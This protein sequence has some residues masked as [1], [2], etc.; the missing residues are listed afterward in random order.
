MKVEAVGDAALRVTVAETPGAEASARVRALDA[1][2]RAAA[3]PGVRAIVPAYTTLLVHFD[4]L[5]AGLVLLSDAIAAVAPQTVAPPQRRWHIAATYD[6]EDLDAVA[7]QLGLSP[8]A[9]VA[10]HSAAQY[11]VACL[12]FAPGFAYLT[13]LPTAL[14]VPRRASP[15]PQIP[16]G[17]LIV[18]GQQTAVMPLPLPSGWHILGRTHLALFDAARAEPSLLLPGDWVRFVPTA[19]A[20]LA[21]AAVR[22]E[23][24]P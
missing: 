8:A 19:A 18:G 11:A 15:R 3:L 4:P 23:A 12:G 7:A 10:Q 13:G 6:G 16:A 2:L 14:H 21:T 17:S 24:L 22:C 9:V 20:L 1:A 5:A